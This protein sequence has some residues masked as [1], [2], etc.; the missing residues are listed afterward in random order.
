M[1]IYLKNK[2]GHTWLLVKHFLLHSGEIYLNILKTCGGIRVSFSPRPVCLV[3][4]SDIFRGNFI[5]NCQ[6]S[7][8]LI[9]S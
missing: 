7:R 9:G 4:S 8:A 3:S 5:D 6:N 1:C 2:N